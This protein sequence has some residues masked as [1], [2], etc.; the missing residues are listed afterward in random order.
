MRIFPDGRWTSV[1]IQ[2]GSWKGGYWPIIDK[3][4]SS[5]QVPKYACIQITS[6]SERRTGSTN[7]QLQGRNTLLLTSHFTTKQR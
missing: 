6:P 7:S 3:R 2:L 4:F 1:D 5:S